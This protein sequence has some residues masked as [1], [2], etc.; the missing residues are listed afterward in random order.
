MFYLFRLFYSFLPLHNPIGFGAA[1]FIELALA[2]L[3]VAMAVWWQRSAAA[4]NRFAVRTVWC[5]GALAAAPVVLRLS[6]LHSSP[7]PTPLGA[8][9]FSYL[10]LGDTLAHFRLTNPMHP[11]HRF[12]ETFFVIQEPSYSSI[13]PLGPGLALAF[14]QLVFRLPWA[15]IALATAA[16]TA[17]CYWMLRGWTK[18]GWALLGG[19]LA[20]VEFGPLNHWM[21]TYWGGSLAAAAGCL[22]FGAMP[23]LKERWRTRDALLLGAGLAIHVLTRPFESILLGICA[24][25]FFV[26]EFRRRELWRAT[27]IAASL[28]APALALIA[29]HDHRVTGNWATLPYAWC[30]YQYGVPSTFT[31]QPNPVPHREL[32]REQKISYDVQSFVHGEGTDTWAT[33]LSRLAQ[34]VRFYRFF[35]LPPLYLALPAFFW[36]W[37]D[38]RMRYVL[39]AL[40]I[41]FFGTSFYGY[42]YAHY[43]AA[44]ACLFLLVT[45][46]SLENLSRLT[47]RGRL[48]GPDAVR[49]IL[50]LCGA[51]FLFWYGVQLSS[52]QDFAKDLEPYE[53]W[54]EVN[55]GDLDGRI[56][57]NRQLA[58]LP[59]KQ[60]VFV[61]YWPKHTLTE[62]V[63]NGAEI[64]RQSVVF[65][66]DL[67]AADNEALSA[68]YP[69]RVAW[70]LEPDAMPPRLSPYRR[71]EPPK[72]VA[73]AA[74][75]QTE[76]QKELS[77]K[78]PRLKF[79]EVK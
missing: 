59:G 5:M 19:A 10:L 22:V 76:Q 56:A 61:R 1:D 13:Y 25:L 18:P 27:A 17:L 55:H 34:R 50:F 75:L 70:L 20:V 48:A 7:I 65:A 51:H 72:P 44:V 77:K 36:S 62:W 16:F 73:P 3:L 52:S 71:E 69:D 43:I 9:D 38:P 2:V 68:Y 60:L 67:G 42:F 29:L 49:V 54:D 57:V 4:V 23:R 47:I 39:A 66:R 33:Y 46:V 6:M 78:R 40:V 35:F 26:P 74:I 11:M 15:G 63:Y 41:F 12:F 32:T 53:T 58:Q 31:F 21:N 28:V 45:V 37:R 14:G 24:A 64:D 30:R 8:D 79:E